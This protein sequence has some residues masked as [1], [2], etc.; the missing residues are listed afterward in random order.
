MAR[1][2]VVVSGGTG[3]LGRSAVTALL[4]EGHDVDVV[5]RRPQN[6][7]LIESLGARARPADLFDVDSLVPVYD[8]AD[9]VV[10]LA[11]NMPVGPR[12]AIGRAWRRH[13]ALHTR[14]VRNVVAAAKR[15]AVRRVV[16]QSASV[17]YADGGDRWLDEESP[18]EISPVTEPAAVAESTV[19]DYCCGSRTGVVLRFGGVIGD[20]EQTRY[21]LRAAA[22][23]KPVGFGSPES[24]T[25]LVHTDDIGSAVAASL[26][27]PTG[28]YNVGAEPV[29]RGELVEGFAK[30]AGVPSSGFL[31]PVRRLMFGSHL[32]PMTRSLRV[33]SD[34]FHT[35]TGWSPLRRAF[36][37]SWLEPDLVAPYR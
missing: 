18:I 3:V 7:P 35:A 8:G 10:N 37:P 27:A 23:G 19:Q 13:D 24:W 5:A 36:D 22:A 14:A 28:V 34:R 12:S 25:H 11:T 16:Q 4:R 1:V 15:A 26:A 29:R 30:A 6:V 32:E 21:W 2:R 17:V 33:S 20:D 9:A 31:G